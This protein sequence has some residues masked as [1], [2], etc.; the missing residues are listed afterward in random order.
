MSWVVYQKITMKKI[1]QLNQW[2]TGLCTAF[3]CFGAI[4]YNFQRT[5]DD[6]YVFKWCKTNGIE[7]NDW[8][9]ARNVGKK[10]A[11]S[12]WY[13]MKEFPLSDIPKYLAKWFAV[14]VSMRV[15][16]GFWRWDFSMVWE[17]HK[18]T[19]YLVGDITGD[20][21]INSQNNSLP[22]KVSLKDLKRSWFHSVRA[23][24]FLR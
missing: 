4:M 9:I 17:K 7:E 3:A 11:Q 23:F 2:S 24:T 5:F 12:F 1:I 13:T 22:L 16:T 8:N 20:Y 14:V 21:F 19:V 15:P 10:V 18:H 6:D